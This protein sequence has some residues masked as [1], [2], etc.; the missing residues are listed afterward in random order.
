MDAGQ[1]RPETKVHVGEKT[2]L[3]IAGAHGHGPGVSVLNL[4]VD[5]GKRGVEGAGAGVGNGRWAAPE[6]RGRFRPKPGRASGEE[7]HHLFVRG[8]LKARVFA[9]R[10]MTG[11]VAP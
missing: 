7:D 9:G 2:V 5:V 1:R 11:R 4:D 8:V 6:L 10:T 3:G